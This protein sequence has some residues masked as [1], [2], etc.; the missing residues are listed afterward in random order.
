MERLDHYLALARSEPRSFNHLGFVAA[1]FEAVLL[2]AAQCHIDL[3][4]PSL[5]GSTT[6]TTHSPE[7]I[8]C[9]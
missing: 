2:H 5:C 6:T 9:P 1:Q 4:M 7:T 8:G 3:A